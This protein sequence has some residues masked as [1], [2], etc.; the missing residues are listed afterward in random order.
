MK[1]S[2]T[3]LDALVNFIACACFIAIKV[4]CGNHQRTVRK[5]PGLQASQPLFPKVEVNM[6]CGIANVKIRKNG[7][8]SWHFKS[9]T[10]KSQ[11]AEVDVVAKRHLWRAV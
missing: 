9:R 1:Q 2:Y 4:L 7:Y 3:T 8:C 11:A 5:G 6:S 10:F